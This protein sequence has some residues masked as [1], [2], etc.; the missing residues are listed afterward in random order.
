MGEAMTQP[1]QDPMEVARKIEI[2]IECYDGLDGGRASREETRKIIAKAIQADR[3]EAHDEY[4]RHMTQRNLEWV[5]ACE[6]IA[7]LELENKRLIEINQE[8]HVY[9]TTLQP[10]LADLRQV[11]QG[12]REEVEFLTE[13]RSNQAH[14]IK[15][16][17]SE[18]ANLKGDQK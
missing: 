5:G 3:L 12:L 4:Q 6:R 1:Q 17:Q 10:E 9:V 18:V 7:E 16:L 13:V 8:N 2:E 15:C 14:L 11:A